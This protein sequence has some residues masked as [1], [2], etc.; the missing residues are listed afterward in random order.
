MAKKSFVQKYQT[1]IVG[2]AAIATVLIIATGLGG[3]N[4][5]LPGLSLT[6]GFTFNL[7]GGTPLAPLNPEKEYYTYTVSQNIIP[8]PVCVGDTITASINTNI[9]N[10]VCSIFI[11][12]GTGFVLLGN[13]YLD[14]SGNFSTTETM[15][16][17][18]VAT[19]RTICCD[20][21]GNCRI[22][23]DITLVV[24]TAIPPCPAPTPPPSPDSDG[25]GF[26]DEEEEAADTNPYD[27]T[28]YPGSGGSGGEDGYT[29]GLYTTCL[30][31]CPDGYTC[32]QIETADFAWCACITG[33]AEG[34]VHP[35]WKPGGTYYN[36]WEI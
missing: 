31:S 17:P 18:G 33:G 36:P 22:A 15:T 29:C 14:A 26:T 5:N 6:P 16:A 23:N 7:P 3:I 13:V 27:P 2:F 8:N 30:G 1:L 28:D 35:D 9:P 19:F 20:A 21:D 12:P 25:D 34:E 10:G 24:T 32:E 4:L 11:D